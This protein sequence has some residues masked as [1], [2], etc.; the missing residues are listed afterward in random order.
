MKN[1]LLFCN[2]LLQS[3]I[4]EDTLHTCEGEVA[5]HGGRPRCHARLAT[6]RPADPGLTRRGRGAAGRSCQ[7]PARVCPRKYNLSENSFFRQVF[8]GIVQTMPRTSMSR[9]MRHC[10][11]KLVFEEV[12]TCN[13]MKYRGLDDSFNTSHFLTND[14]KFT[15]DDPA[16]SGMCENSSLDS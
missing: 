14:A 9:I 15:A 4:H 13:A 8:R 11:S 10:P 6:S 2:L 1:N 3:S 5:S 12:F 16:R 7:R